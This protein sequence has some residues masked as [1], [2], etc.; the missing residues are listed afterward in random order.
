MPNPSLVLVYLVGICTCSILFINMARSSA[1]A[2]V[3]VSF[4]ELN[5]YPMCPFS[6]YQSI[7]SRNMTNKYGA[8][9]VSLDTFPIWGRGDLVVKRAPRIDVEDL[10]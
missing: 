10:E 9:G 5:L 1:R 6:S 7:V 2:S 4:G 8:K 3:F